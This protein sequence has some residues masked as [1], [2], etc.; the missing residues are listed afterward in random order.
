MP[1]SPNKKVLLIVPRPHGFFS[2]VFQAVGQAYLAEKTGATP[3]VYYNRHC[4]YWSDAGYQGAR[5]VWDYY[6]E[7]LSDLKI[8]D[9]FSLDRAELEDCTPEKFAEL[10]AG[11]DIVATKKYPPVIEFNSP[12][13]VNFQRKFVHRLLDKYLVLKPHIREKLDQ[14]CKGHFKSKFVV[15]V[16]YRGVEKAHGERK[17]WIITRESRDLKEFY[18][19]EMRRYL[20]KHPSARIFIATDSAQFLEEAK[21]AFGDA[22]FA[23]EATRLDSAEESTGLH[24]SDHAKKNGAL[25]GEE[26]LLDAL[27]LAK[28]NLFIHGVSG[29][30]NAVLFFNPRLRHIDIEI[31]HGRTAV[32][33]RREFF[34]Q[35]E[36]MAP[37]VHDRLRRLEDSLRFGK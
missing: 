7:P 13:G 1:P 11:T 2:V 36:R 18:F 26:V 22:V 3:I 4:L 34:R 5:N 20:A 15:G 28:T 17:D 21:A 8:E 37:G 23:R 19:V 9:L 14:F 32:Y 27:I 29:V 35:L 33:V 12:L 16:H 10:A 31:R 30:S 6:F 25:L 24:F